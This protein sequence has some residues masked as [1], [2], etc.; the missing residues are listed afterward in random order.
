MKAI[1]NIEILN[2][3]YWLYL[4]KYIHYFVVHAY[5]AINRKMLM[6]LYILY[7]QTRQQ[8]YLEAVSGYIKEAAVAVPTTTQAI[9]DK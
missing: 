1:N 9:Y 8:Q 4:H 5:S 6:F 2:I 7:R 3:Y